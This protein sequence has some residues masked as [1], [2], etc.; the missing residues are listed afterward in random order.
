MKNNKRNT[1]IL[2]LMSTTPVERSPCSQA[3][4]A[5]HQNSYLWLYVWMTVGTSIPSFFFSHDETAE[6]GEAHPH[7]LPVHGMRLQSGVSSSLRSAMGPIAS[8]LTADRLTGLSQKLII[9]YFFLGTHAWTQVLVDFQIWWWS[10]D[11]KTNTQLSAF[12]MFII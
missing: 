7:P 1:N 5:Y 8:L 12:P 10:A 6:S 4:A 3:N 11:G 9:S 2:T